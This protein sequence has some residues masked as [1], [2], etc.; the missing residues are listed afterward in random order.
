M[1]DRRINPLIKLIP[2][3]T[4]LYFFIPDL[5]LGPIDDALILGVGVYLFIELCPPAIVEE[6]RQALRNVVDGNFRN[7]NDD[8]IPKY[9]DDIIE[10]EFRDE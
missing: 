9:E 1:A 5:I 3:G 6:H 8:H 2:I 4:V 10:G 7:P